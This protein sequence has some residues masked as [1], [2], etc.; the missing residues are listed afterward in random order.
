MPALDLN[1]VFREG[2]R[3]VMLKQFRENVRF[4][5]S[6]RPARIGRAYT[7]LR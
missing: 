7:D 4:S 6:L 1:P 3:C 5:F 2:F